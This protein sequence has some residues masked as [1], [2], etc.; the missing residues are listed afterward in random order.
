MAALMHYKRGDF[1]H[2]NRQIKQ[3]AVN[4]ESKDQQLALRIDWLNVLIQLKRASA[5]S[6]HQADAIGALNVFVDRYP[7]SEMYQL[8]LFERFKL[9]TR[10]LPPKQALKKL[11]TVSRDHP[12]HSAA[13]F[14]VVD[15]LRR[16]WSE[17]NPQEKNRFFDELVIADQNFRALPD[18]DNSRKL[19][20]LLIVIDVAI[21]SSKPPAYVS[22]LLDLAGTILD[23]IP[24]KESQ[25]HVVNYFRF[26]QAKE[27]GDTVTAAELAQSLAIESAIRQHRIAALAFVANLYD[28][29]DQETRLQLGKMKTYELLVAELEGE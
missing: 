28:R 4:S 25:Q 1:A 24:D 17:V 12:F 19:D 6:M 15:C 3:V 23:E 13:Q 7:D 14:E 10:L 22:R 18:V 26:R 20:S 2:A 8:A 9:T 29:E 21:R 5:N 27:S 11:K 16:C